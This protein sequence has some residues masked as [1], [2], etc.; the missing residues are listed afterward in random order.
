MMSLNSDKIKPRVGVTSSDQRNKLAV[1]AI[2]RA[3]KKSGGIPVVITP[4]KNMDQFE[5][6]DGLVVSGGTDI[7][8]LLYKGKND[9]QV[10]YDPDRDKLERTL[11]GAA[12]NKRLPILGI[13]RGFQMMNIAQGGSLHQNLSD[14]FEQFVPTRSVLSKVLARRRVKLDSTGTLA[15]ITLQTLHLYVNSIHHQGI[16]LLAD[17]FRVVARDRHGIIQAIESVD[18]VHFAIGVQWHPEYMPF[19]RNQQMIFRHL[20]KESA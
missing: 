15:K 5:M 6:L 8:P 18:P 2:K 20:V 10:T 16:N 19:S 14:V 1:F 4:K 9:P 12:F 11:V 7:E 17:D 13:C 3:I